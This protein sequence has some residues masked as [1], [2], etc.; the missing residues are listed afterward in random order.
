MAV[1]A[2]N[3]PSKLDFELLFWTTM[4]AVAEIAIASAIWLS[5]AWFTAVFVADMLALFGR[6]FDI[7]TWQH[8]IWIPLL[9]SAIELPIV[10]LWSKMPVMARAVGILVVI[11][12]F[13]STCYGIAKTV[14]GVEVKL[15][16]GVRV[17]TADRSIW[18]TAIG[19]CGSA[20]VTF[21]PEH[22]IFEGVQQL[23]NVVKAVK[24]A[25]GG[26]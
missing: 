18:P 22:A 25:W 2:Q 1:T 5:G 11:F 14:G 19:V 4:A 17:P 26:R 12:D 3:L 20:I 10:K 8:W 21:G 13:G 7:S 24:N 9:V 16:G 15:F 23:W 6:T